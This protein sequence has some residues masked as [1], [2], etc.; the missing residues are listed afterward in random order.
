VAVTEDQA[1]V[2]LSTAHKAKGREWDTVWL[3]D[4]F[5]ET[6]KY[7]EAS[8]TWKVNRGERNLLYVAATRGMKHVH[9]NQ[10]CRMALAKR[11]VGST[12]SIAV[13]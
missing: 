11:Q 1:D 8:E 13:Q 10:P 5:P 3:A 12:A 6:I 4:D 7:D 2:V 9:I